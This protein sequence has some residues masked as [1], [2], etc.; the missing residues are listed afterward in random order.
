[1]TLTPAPGLVYRTIGGV[2][3]LY[4]FLGPEPED[5]VSQYT[6]AV[7]RYY[8]PP[9]WSLGFHLCRWGY[10]S[11]DNMKAAWQRTRDAEI[12]FDVQ[13]GDIDYMD[14]RLDFTVDQDSFAGLAD[15]V[16]ELHE[17][18]MRFGIPNTACNEVC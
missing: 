3:D 16:A 18:G 1:M 7:G 6:A 9:Y 2:L 5:V 17:M 10:N 13:W 4:F 12:P 11:L 8:I 15:F 14:R